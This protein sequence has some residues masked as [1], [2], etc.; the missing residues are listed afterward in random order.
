MT[1]PLA[2][3]LEVCIMTGECCVPSEIHIQIQIQIHKYVQKYT[4]T[5][6]LY[7]ERRVSSERLRNGANCDGEKRDPGKYSKRMNSAQP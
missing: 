4:N 7:Y 6:R 2:H 1:P 5:Q 3:K